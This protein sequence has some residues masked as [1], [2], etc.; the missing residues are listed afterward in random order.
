MLGGRRCLLVIR[1]RFSALFDD[2]GQDSVE[3]GSATVEKQELQKQELHKSNNPAA[4]SI[5]PDCRNAFA[6]SPASGLFLTARRQNR[7]SC[8]GQVERS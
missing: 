1:R 3:K 5:T 2:D 6:F 7:K 8:P 4:P